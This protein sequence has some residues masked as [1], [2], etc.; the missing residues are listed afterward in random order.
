MF[1]HTEN[2]RK[3]VSNWGN[4]VKEMFHNPIQKALVTGQSWEAWCFS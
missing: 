4:R 2:D 1:T 3:L